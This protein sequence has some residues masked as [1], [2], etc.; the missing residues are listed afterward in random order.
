MD[1]LQKVKKPSFDDISLSATPEPLPDAAELKNQTMIQP[2]PVKPV[3]AVAA[4]TSGSS[5]ILGAN[6]NHPLNPPK[7]T[8]VAPRQRPR[9]S[10]NSGAMIAN[11]PGAVP[12]PLPGSSKPGKPYSQYTYLVE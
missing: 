8:S 5:P 4:V 7:E 6:L 3:A 10:A 2:S 1:I 9:G 12:L 11:N